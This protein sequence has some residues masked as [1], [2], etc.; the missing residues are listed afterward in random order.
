MVIAVIG[1]TGNGKST[2]CNRLF[3]DESKEGDKGPF[4]V[5]EMD[6]GT[7]N[8]NYR[9]KWVSIGNNKNANIV[10]V[11]TPG[12]NDGTDNNNNKYLNNIGDLVKTCHHINAF[13]IVI[14]YSDMS[15]RYRSTKRAI[16]SFEQLLSKQMYQHLIL[17]ITRVEGNNPCDNNGYLI[18]KSVSRKI[19]KIK[20]ALFDDV[21][22]CN[23]VELVT[24][25]HNDYKNKVKK[26]LSMV[27]NNAF[28]GKEIVT[29]PIEILQTQLDEAENALAD[30][31]N[32][33]AIAEQMM[34]KTKSK[35]NKA[36]AE[37]RRLQR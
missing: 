20:S 23:N 25:G 6:V 4:E 7:L 35:L 9:R 22:I 18:S 12:L 27:K 5:S 15:M 32:S 13:F 30:A 11:D 21:N 10:I 14:K 26:L 31:Q 28:N 16:K 3:G 29:R 1:E 8:V 36:E 34:N 33:Q 2:L 24:I 19:T 37:L 17:V